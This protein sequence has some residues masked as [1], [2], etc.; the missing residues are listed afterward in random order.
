MQYNK[1]YIKPEERF[2]KS[3]DKTKYDWNKNTF[4]LNVVKAKGNVL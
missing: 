3:K 1:W 2:S 4:I